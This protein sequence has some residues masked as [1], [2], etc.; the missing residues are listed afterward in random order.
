[1]G[2]MGGWAKKKRKQNTCR[3]SASISASRLYLRTLR[4]TLTASESASRWLSRIWTTRP[5]VPF[6]SCATTLYRPPSKV[7]PTRSM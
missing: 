7:S 4:T 6:P 2:E 5:N 1:M 3:I